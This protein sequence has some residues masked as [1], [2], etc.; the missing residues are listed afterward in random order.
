M[1]N[2]LEGLNSEL[3]KK[4]KVYLKEG[5]ED[6]DKLREYSRIKGIKVPEDYLQIVSLN[7]KIYINVDDELYLGVWGAEEC[8]EMN[9]AFNI[10]EYVTNGIAVADN[11][12]GG[13]LIYME[14]N[15]GY[16][17]Y[18]LGFGNLFPEEGVYIAHSLR[19]I[20]VKGLGV[21][22]LKENY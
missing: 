13:C 2:E 5:A 16:G 20:L 8:V 9:E 19:D 12:G 14:G 1:K 7:S 21:H 4:L 6:V 22:T 17:V 11:G 15:K 10:Q 3:N 18:Q